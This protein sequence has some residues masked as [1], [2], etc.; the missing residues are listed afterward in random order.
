MKIDHEAR[1]AIIRGLEQRDVSRRR[2]WSAFSEKQGLGRPSGIIDRVERDF[3]ESAMRGMLMIVGKSLE[4]HESLPATPPRREA[5]IDHALENEPEVFLPGALPDELFARLTEVGWALFVFDYN[6]Q[7]EM[8]ATGG[9]YEPPSDAFIND[10]LA[11]NKAPCR[12]VEGRIE[13]TEELAAEQPLTTD[14]ADWPRLRE[15]IA[16]MRERF[17]AA[18]GPDDYSDVGNR[19]IRAI[20]AVADLAFEPATDLPE[21]DDPPKAD[22]A[23]R[24]LDLFFQARLPGKDA[25]PMRE[26]SSAAWDIAQKVKHRQNP[27]RKETGA[28]VSALCLLVDLVEA[29]SNPPACGS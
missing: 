6:D 14:L 20:T 13:W 17:R 1:V 21:K 9:P 26:A 10:A 4:E 22:A 3:G 12:M 15:E 2:L 7:F 27:T 19:C 11:K 5:F 28:A 16:G 23:K 24:K 18:T 8:Y 29:A 25:K